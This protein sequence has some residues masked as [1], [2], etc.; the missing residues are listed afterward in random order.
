MRPADLTGAVWRKSTRS[1]SNAD[2]LEFADL[3]RAVAVRD[4]K[5]PHGPVLAFDPM[6]WSGFL[7]GLTIDSP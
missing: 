6:S 7:R 4:S 2:C 3:G 1:G 5:D